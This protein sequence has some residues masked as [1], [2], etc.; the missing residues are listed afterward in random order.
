MKVLLPAPVTPIT[1]MNAHGAPA[2]TVPTLSAIEDP[3]RDRSRIEDGGHCLNNMN[4][5]LP[6]VVESLLSLLGKVGQSTTGYSLAPA[7]SQVTVRK[8]RRLVKNG[9]GSTGRKGA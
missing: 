6:F 3:E 9:C 5:M 2:T 8:P 7:M 1:A 4:Y